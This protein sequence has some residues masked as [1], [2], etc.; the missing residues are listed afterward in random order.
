MDNNGTCGVWT[1]AI[2]RHHV[3]CVCVRVSL[4]NTGGLCHTNVTIPCS[5]VWAV[6]W[7]S[8]KTQPIML[9]RT[10]CDDLLIIIMY[11]WTMTNDDDTCS[12]FLFVL[13]TRAHEC[14][15]A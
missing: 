13:H 2:I 8:S 11:T 14:T 12:R 4:F 3:Y 9:V 15:S 6:E 1:V 7:A 5:I 10:S